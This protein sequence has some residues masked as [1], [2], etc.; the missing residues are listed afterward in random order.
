MQRDFRP[1]G[2]SLADQARAWLAAPTASAQPRLAS[3]VMLLRDCAS[4]PEVFSLR[5]VGSMT[6]APKVTVF[7]GG[8][9]DQRDAEGEVPWAGPSVAEWAEVLETDEVTARLL[10]CAAI[11]EVFEECGVLLAGPDEHSIVA[12][13]S[14]PEWHARR[15]A[16]EARETSLTD[17]LTD[18][19]LVLR[20]DAVFYRAHWVTPDFE[21]RRFDA[22][23]FAARLPEGQ[24]PDDATS[25]TD[26]VRWARPADLLDEFTRG[27]V[28]LMP[29]TIVALEQIAEHGSVDAYVAHP[30]VIRP[31][32]PWPEEVDGEIVLRADLP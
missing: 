14:G 19:G 21:P 5:R 32:Q 25:E 27:E 30:P 16:L 29:P 3:T 13:V 9:V 2:T 10:V 1:R 15:L 31:V 7:P 12:D 11:R 6:F 24:H 17:L 4:G 18:T 8:G 28:I 26:L 20:T 23:F 22:R